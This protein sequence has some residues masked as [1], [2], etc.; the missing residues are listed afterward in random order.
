MNYKFQFS[1]F[2]KVTQIDAEVSRRMR[3]I[4][5]DLPDGDYEWILRPKIRWDTD[6]QRKYFHGPVLKF[7]VEQF[8]TLGHVV[9]KDEAKQWVKERFGPVREVKLGIGLSTAMP[10][11]TAE[12]DF[13]TYKGVL[14]GLDKWCK[15]YCHC[16][17]PTAE[18]IE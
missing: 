15:D 18:E 5:G 9:S 4:V 11:S 17:L 14:S 7:L 8:K 6:Q 2:L 16:N 1:R 10:K 13:E 12:W 3:S